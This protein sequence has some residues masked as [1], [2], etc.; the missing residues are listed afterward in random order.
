MALVVQNDQ[1]SVDDAN[2]Y[3]N[4]AFLKAH[5]DARG[6]NYSAYPDPQIEAAG[7]RATDYMDG[8]WNFIGDR[9][10][11]EQGT[12]FPRHNAYDRD[13]NYVQGIPSEVKKAW[14]EYTFIEL[15]SGPLEATPQR[16]ATG[17]RV[18][19]RSESV[20]PV[21]ESVTYAAGA[22]YQKPVYPVPDSLLKRRGLVAA[23]GQIVRG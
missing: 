9:V 20:G 10:R 2:A 7:V 4:L 23:G 21:S 13:R 18:I 12:A 15:T 19:Q 17:A 16:D 1:G 5:F 8:R 22:A 6:Y 14:A 11:G 3:E